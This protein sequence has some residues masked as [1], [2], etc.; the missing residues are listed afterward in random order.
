[1]VIKV[2]SDLNKVKEIMDD[3]KLFLSSMPDEEVKEYLRGTWEPKTDCIY[4]NYKDIAVVALYNISNLTVDIHPKLR[5]EYWGSGL[6]DELQE[7]IEDWLKR[8]TGYG[9]MI[10]QTPECCREVLQ[11][12]VR[13]GYYLE[14]LLTAGILWRGKVENIVLMSKFLDRGNQHG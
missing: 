3:K 1:M 6:S 5:S 13:N 12:A 14:G 2:E 7:A 11:A 4:L 8:N 9:K 10:I